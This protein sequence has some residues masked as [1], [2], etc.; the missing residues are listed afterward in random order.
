MNR[1]RTKAFVLLS[2]IFLGIA[3]VFVLWTAEAKGVNYIEMACVLEERSPTCVDSIPEWK[4]GLAYYDSVLDLEGDTL[5]ALKMLLWEFWNVEFAG[6]G[7]GSV[8]MDAILPLRVLENRKSGCVGLSFLSLMVSEARN[9]PLHAVLLP[10]H[11][12]LRYGSA[13]ERNGSVSTD[14]GFVNLEPNR[15]GYSYSDEE[16]REKY[17]EGKWTGLEFKSLSSSE[18]TGLVAF[19]MGNLYLKSDL[20]KSLF[21][22]RFADEF[23]PE[24][25]GI[26]E[27]REYAKAKLY[28]GQ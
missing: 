1:K 19:D 28:G 24:Y 15:N 13:N 9:I 22:Y 5:K 10:A 2:A 25:P 17:R 3:F 20:Q 23:F 8:S 11:V 7:E 16:Y 18:F 4:M 14:D 6:D 21:W 26:R 27:N 12:F